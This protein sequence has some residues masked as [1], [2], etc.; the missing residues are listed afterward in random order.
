MSPSANP[1]PEAQVVRLP[2][3]SDAIGSSLRDAYGSEDR[4]T[5]EIERLLGMLHRVT[6]TRQ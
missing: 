2:R 1:R 4:I 3:A 6:W 5:D